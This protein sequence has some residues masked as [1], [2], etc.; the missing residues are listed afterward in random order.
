M[1]IGMLRLRKVKKIFKVVKWK[2]KKTESQQSRSLQP[3]SHIGK[4]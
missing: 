3:W 4:F 2:R 1:K